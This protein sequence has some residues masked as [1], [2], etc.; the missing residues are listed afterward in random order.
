MSVTLKL[1]TSLDGRIATASG[2][3]RWITGPA[4]REEVHRLRAIHMAVLV[5]VDTVIADDPEL[6]VRLPGYVGPQPRRVVLDS[7]LRIPPACKLVET[8]D[9]IPTIVVTTKD[10][11]DRLTDAGVTVLQVE[12]SDGRVDPAAA[13]AALEAAG[14]GA[15]M[16][17]GGGQVAASFL[18]ADL[19]DAVEWFRAPIVLG[20]EGRPA[21]GAFP[22]KALAAAPRFR[23]LSIH[24]V[25]DDLWERYG[26]S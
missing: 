11:N 5:G 13:L 9:R 7:R 24:E 14:V 18:G 20:D 21:V 6:T 1:A 17:E 10:S 2:E 19:V 23:R 15:V 12:A 26:R 16:I 3:S 25:G 4:A 8:A 22:L